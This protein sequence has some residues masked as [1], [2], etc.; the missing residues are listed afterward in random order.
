MRKKVSASQHPDDS[1]EVNNITTSLPQLVTAP[2]AVMANQALQTVSSSSSYEDNT[3]NRL[4]VNP[5]P[6][7]ATSHFRESAMDAAGL[8]RTGCSWQKQSG[9]EPVFRVDNVDVHTALVSLRG[10]QNELASLEQDAFSA[11]LCQLYSAI[12]GGGGDKAAAM[13]TVATSSYT[14][15]NQDWDATLDFSGLW[16]GL[17]T[18]IN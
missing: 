3:E 10:E 5:Q 14:S 11:I 17:S 7:L 6:N 4:R 12:P 8:S 16:N 1:Y 18:I 13:S 2:H 9:E 15:Y